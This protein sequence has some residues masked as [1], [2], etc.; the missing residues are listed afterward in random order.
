MNDNLNKKG[1]RDRQR[2][3]GTQEHEVR[4]FAKEAGITV[5]QVRELIGR[6]GNDREILMQEA[7][8]LA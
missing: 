7:K 2:V 1:F 6:Y 8:R 5:E 3:A 4:Y